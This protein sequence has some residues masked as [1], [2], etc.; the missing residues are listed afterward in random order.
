MSFWFTRRDRDGK[1]HVYSVSASPQIII[2]LMII[3]F[4]F[5][6]ELIRGC[7]P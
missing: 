4:V 3:L 6:A 5:V 2:L 1:R 7:V